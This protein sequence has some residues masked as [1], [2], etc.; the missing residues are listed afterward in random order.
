MKS[1]TVIG[2]PEPRLDGPE[3]VTGGAIYTI[4]VVLPSMLHAK[5]LR[6]PV[7]HATIRRVDASRARA[8]AGVA[9]VLTADDVPRKRFGFSLQDEQ[10]FAGDK[11]R[12]IGDVIA[13]VAADDEQSAEHAASLIDCD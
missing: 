12:Y 5:L 4:D 11:V 8:V 13:A 7:P 2:K 6:S 9:A 1:F 10:I 3:T